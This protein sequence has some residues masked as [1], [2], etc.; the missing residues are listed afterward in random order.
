MSLLWLSDP[1]A[2][3]L[4]FLRIPIYLRLPGRNPADR[5]GGAQII[6]SGAS[7]ADGL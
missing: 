3:E 1:D 6:S 7:A 5:A 2:E 4:P